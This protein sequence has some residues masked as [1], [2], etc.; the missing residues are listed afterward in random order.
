M[1]RAHTGW[2]TRWPRRHR[3]RSRAEQVGLG[4]LDPRDLVPPLPELEERVLHELLGVMA[5]AR[6]EYRA[7]KSLSCSSAKNAS[8]P[9]EVTEALR[10]TSAAPLLA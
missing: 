4:V 6:L 1:T 9:I 8:N 5:I 2:R 10:R 7:L 3:Y